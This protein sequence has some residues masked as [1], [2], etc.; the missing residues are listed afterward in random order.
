MKGVRVSRV[1]RRLFVVSGLLLCCSSGSASLPD[2]R[3]LRLAILARQA[4]AQDAALAP[5]TVGVKVSN[6]VVTL[7]GSLPTPELVS[8]AVATVEKTKGIY[9]VRSELTVEPVQGELPDLL[10]TDNEKLEAALPFRTPEATTLTGQPLPP[11]LKPTP[12]AGVSLQAPVAVPEKP[13]TPAL[14]G[15]A[16]RARLEQLRQD[17]RFRR[18]EMRVEDGVVIL[19]GVVTSIEQRMDLARAVAKL[20]GVRQVSTLELRIGR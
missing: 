7:W 9:Q 6:G 4:L 16:L 11:P 8:R 5:F 2:S 14:S 1:L 3:D 12:N 17:P 13:T 20:P 10:R 19:S 15:D 18:V